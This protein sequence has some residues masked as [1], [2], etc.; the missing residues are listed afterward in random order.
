[1]NRH[2][3]TV[4]EQRYRSLQA[5]GYVGMCFGAVVMALALF[6]LVFSGSQVGAIAAVSATGV[7]LVVSW[8][9]FWRLH[10]SDGVLRE[11]DVDDL[12]PGV[13]GGRPGLLADRRM[14]ARSDRFPATFGRFDRFDR[15]GYDGDPG[16]N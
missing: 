4:L 7:G 11:I 3:R 2:R 10:A 12:R 1:M 6:L 5:G 8:I 13:G 14:L 15:Y 9:G 16:L